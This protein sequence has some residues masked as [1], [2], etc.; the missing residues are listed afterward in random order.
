MYK[1]LKIHITKQAMKNNNSTPPNARN[2]AKADIPEL[3]KREKLE[4]QTA[5]KASSAEAA[6]LKSLTNKSER[7]ISRTQKPADAVTTQHDKKSKLAKVKETPYFDVYGARATTD[8]KAPYSVP[9]K[10]TQTLKHLRNSIGGYFE[11]TLS[12]VPIIGGD[13]ID[14]NNKLRRDT[15]RAKEYSVR[16]SKLE[17]DMIESLRILFTEDVALPDANI[18]ETQQDE[19][20]SKIDAGLKARTDYDLKKS[21]D[22][23]TSLKTK[24]DELKDTFD[25][26]IFTRLE[27]QIEAQKKIIDAEKSSTA[28]ID[29]AETELTRLKTE[30]KPLKQIKK[31]ISAID[32]QLSEEK[33]KLKLLEAKAEDKTGDSSKAALLLKI[34]TKNKIHQA[35]NPDS[36]V[37]NSNLKIFANLGLRID[38]PN[39]EVDLTDPK[40]YLKLID[41]IV[42]NKG[43]HDVSAMISSLQNNSFLQDRLLNQ[44]NI[45]MDAQSKGKHQRKYTY[46]SNRHD[47]RVV[48]SQLRNIQNLKSIQFEGE[49]FEDWFKMDIANR[50]SVDPLNNRAFK[51]FAGEMNT[52]VIA[53]EKVLL[54]TMDN[55]FVTNFGSTMASSAAN[56]YVINSAA[57]STYRRIHGHDYQELGAPTQPTPINRPTQSNPIPSFLPANNDPQAIDKLKGVSE[58]DTTESTNNNMISKTEGEFISKYFKDKDG[59]IIDTVGANSLSADNQI[60]SISALSG[61]SGRVVINE[62]IYNSPQVAK[63]LDQIYIHIAKS[64]VGNDHYVIVKN[65]KLVFMDAKGVSKDI[66]QSKIIDNYTAKT[67][68]TPPAPRPLSPIVEKKSTVPPVQNPTIEIDVEKTIESGNNLNIPE[69]YEDGKDYL[70]QLFSL[71]PGLFIKSIKPNFDKPDTINLITNTNR[72]DNKPIEIKGEL[73]SYI[74]ILFSRNNEIKRELKGLD[75][76]TFKFLTIALPI[77]RNQNLGKSILEISLQNNYTEINSINQIEPLLTSLNDIE[78]TSISNIF[79][80]GKIIIGP[81]YIFFRV[82][83]NLEIPY[84]L[85]YIDADYPIYAQNTEFISSEE[86]D[87]S[88]FKDTLMLAHNYREETKFANIESIEITNNNKIEFKYTDSDQSFILE[89]G[90]GAKSLADDLI[91]EFNRLKESNVIDFVLTDGKISEYQHK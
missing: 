71:N 53:M 15:Q 63:M 85:K 41:I 29:A 64:T 68:S 67:N 88:E 18:D 36:A 37:L 87:I 44:A 23:V 73:K 32:D 74:E 89:F 83:K 20:K 31:E 33:T 55:N 43:G 70:S 16:I 26:D 30:I 2:R 9:S 46:H 3:S 58:T 4:A 11:R 66:P 50:S 91:K 13:A 22:K 21:K 65:G 54:Q 38:G 80:I 59:F 76:E 60:K 77:L 27:A 42:N 19:M 78:R 61:P 5:A 40:A 45:D 35:T 62:N 17:V 72:V 82:N 1:E 28:D 75:F 47:L 24:K 14:N 79:T 69:N 90:E 7:T 52:R 8:S 10:L 6:T 25:K 34:Q 48:F 39:P 49:E 12:A 84:P 81:S 86:D 57:R 56:Y 51:Q